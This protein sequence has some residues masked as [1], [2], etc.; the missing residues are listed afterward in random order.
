MSQVL[1]ILIKSIRLLQHK[2][3]IDTTI[4]GEEVPKVSHGERERELGQI[5][6]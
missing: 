4:D 6:V 1:T 5:L 3:A 2:M